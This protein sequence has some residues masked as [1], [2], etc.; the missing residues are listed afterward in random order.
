MGSNLCQEACSSKDGLD[1]RDPAYFTSIGEETAEEALAFQYDVSP[2]MP[3]YM[4]GGNIDVKE[5]HSHGLT[6]VPRL[7]RC[8]ATGKA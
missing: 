1:L 8:S 4:K 7:E 5:V 3:S 6:T 2:S